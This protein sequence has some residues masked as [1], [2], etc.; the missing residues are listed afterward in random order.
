MHL[1]NKWVNKDN[2]RIYHYQISKS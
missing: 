2:S 1:P